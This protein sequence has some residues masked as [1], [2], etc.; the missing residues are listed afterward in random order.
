MSSTPFSYSIFSFSSFSILVL[1]FATSFSNFSISLLLPKIFTVFLA[2]EPPVIA[3]DG[4][5]TSPSNVIILNAYEFCFATFTAVSILSTITVLPNKFNIICSYFLS[6]LIKSEAIPINPFS[7]PF[8]FSNFFP[9]T[10]EIGKKVPLPK[11]FFLICST[12]L[13]ASSSVSVTI[14]CKLAPKHISIAVCTSSG[15]SI[16]FA[17]TPCIPFPN[18]L[19]FSQS[20][21]SIFTLLIYPSFSFSVSIKNFNLE[22]LILISLDSMFILLSYSFTF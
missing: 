8:I 16:T 1:R 17:N 9:L 22:S 21:R 11:L 4:F 15:T 12:S 19:I 13:F 20:F 14:F 3:P 6:Y 18:S 5:I 2:T 7:C 10:D